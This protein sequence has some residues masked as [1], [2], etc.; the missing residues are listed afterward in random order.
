MKKQPELSIDPKAV[1]GPERFCYGF[2]QPQLERLKIL[3]NTNRLY[4]KSTYI[5]SEVATL[6]NNL[7]Q[8]LHYDRQEFDG[9][10]VGTSVPANA[11][12]ALI[13]HGERFLAMFET[14]EP[15]TSQSGTITGFNQSFTAAILQQVRQKLKEN[16]LCLFPTEDPNKF[17]LSCASAAYLNTLSSQIN[18]GK[19][20]TFDART[21]TD[22]SLIMAI[23]EAAAEFLET[24][25]GK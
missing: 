2:A 7:S 23:I 11:I 6:L 22:W 25:E 18:A 17:F 21:P 20:T 9:R 3:A 14:K 19:G 8:Q 10:E 13:E 16:T 12:L 15:A 4:S 24:S 5:S 1:I